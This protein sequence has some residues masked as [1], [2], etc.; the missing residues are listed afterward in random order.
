MNLMNLLATFR[1]M[2]A[3]TSVLVAASG[4][5]QPFAYI[6]GGHSGDGVN[7]TF[8]QTFLTAARDQERRSEANGSVYVTNSY[9]GL[10][11]AKL[12]ASID[13][14]RSSVN[15]PKLQMAYSSCGTYDVCR[16]KSRTNPGAPL[17]L[18]VDI[19]VTGGAQ[20]S[21]FAAGD[22]NLLLYYKVLMLGSNG[23]TG[24][25]QVYGQ[26]GGTGFMLYSGP[27]L[28]NMRVGPL[29]VTENVPFNME[30]NY[31]LQA[32]AFSSSLGHL[33]AGT[34]D[35]SNT[36]RV[37]GVYVTDAGDNPVTTFRIVSALKIDYTKAANPAV[38]KNLLLSSDKVV[39]GTTVIGTVNLDQ[40]AEQGG[41]TV[42]LATSKRLAT[43]PGKRVIPY[44]ETSATFPIETLAVG[45]TRTVDI[46]AKMAGVTK[47]KT[48]TLT[49]V[50]P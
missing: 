16:V 19:G 18:Y 10:N 27:T 29:M 42:T 24:S 32:R 44:L 8:D 47:I 14:S 17:K 12:I 39:G 6:Q 13:A 48:L 30:L 50:L 36:F 35:F 22:T 41:Q 3:L 40:R 23:A 49:P 11:W 38:L 4:G 45:M 31:Q 46:I 34:I 1:G 21:F 37:K 26:W 20:G 33:V 25:N 28:G 2:V 9:V 7:S 15:S 43:V 5:A